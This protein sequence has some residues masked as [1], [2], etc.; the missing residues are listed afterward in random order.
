MDKRRQSDST[1][2]YFIDEHRLYTWRTGVS[3][4]MSF[5]GVQGMTVAILQTGKRITWED[6]PFNQSIN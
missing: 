2:V 1:V 5:E 6:Y 3:E 4:E